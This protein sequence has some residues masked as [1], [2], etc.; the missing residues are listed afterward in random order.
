MDEVITGLGGSFADKTPLPEQFGKWFADTQAKAAPTIK[1]KLQITRSFAVER[2]EA[3]VDGS[4][5]M[6]VMVTSVKATGPQTAR[7]LAAKKADFK[8]ESTKKGGSFDEFGKVSC[9]VTADKVP[10][11]CIVWTADGWFETEIL[12]ASMVTPKTGSQLLDAMKAIA[13]KG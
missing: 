11:G 4:A 2:T 10:H 8:A 3:Y 1:A 5:E 6:L 9:Q 13:P 12:P 7:M